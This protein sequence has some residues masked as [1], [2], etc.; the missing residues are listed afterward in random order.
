MV[1]EACLFCLPYLPAGH[2]WLT[3]SCPVFQD[4]LSTVLFLNMLK[5]Q[6]MT[7]IPMELSKLDVTGSS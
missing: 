5:D 7:N 4:K 6:I 2:C 1:V 3:L